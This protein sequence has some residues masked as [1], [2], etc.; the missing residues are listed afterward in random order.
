MIKKTYRQI[1]SNYLR[2][3]AARYYLHIS[4]QFLFFTHL[5]LKLTLPFQIFL[6]PIPILAQLIRLSG[7]P[8]KR[9]YLHISMK[10]LLYLFLLSKPSFAFQISLFKKK[11]YKPLIV[12]FKSSLFIPF[13]KY[14]RQNS[15]SLIRGRVTP[16]IKLILV[17]VIYVKPKYLYRWSVFIV[18]R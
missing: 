3:P 6:F 12:C 14:L 5:L 11:V 16:S 13:D 10:F 4:M 8:A 1:I 7:S 15:W 18:F 17:V 2:S 9:Y